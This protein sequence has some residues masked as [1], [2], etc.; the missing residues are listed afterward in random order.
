VRTRH[1]LATAEAVLAE[2]R[3]DHAEAADRHAACAA[4]WLAYGSVL[5][6]AH[7]LAGEG[8]SRLALG[9]REGAGEALPAARLAYAQ[10]GAAPWVREVD[11]LLAQHELAAR[12]PAT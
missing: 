7:A 5:E 3:G 2:A 4:A 11:R 9:D 10:L 8:R 12:T 6:R 1:A